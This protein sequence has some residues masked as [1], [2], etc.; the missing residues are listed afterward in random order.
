MQLSSSHFFFQ[1]VLSLA[2]SSGKM[3]VKK[4]KLDLLKKLL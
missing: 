1:L 4:E 2:K 3:K